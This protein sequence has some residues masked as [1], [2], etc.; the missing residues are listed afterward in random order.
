MGSIKQRN[1][2]KRQRSRMRRHK[3]SIL[4]I[5]GVIILLAIISA[6]GSVSLQAKNSNYKQLEA[7]LQVQLEEEKE[8]SEEIT[9]LEKYVGTDAYIE[10]VAKE[11][12][13]LIYQNEILFQ[14]ET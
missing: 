8:R 5:C 2:D 4:S 7:E 9:D 13:G 6:V 14:P 1:R 3:K 12:L 10:D 11:K